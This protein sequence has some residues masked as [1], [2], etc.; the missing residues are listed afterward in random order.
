MKRFI[1]L[2]LLILGLGLAIACSEDEP[3]IP[4]P[5]FANVQVPQACNPISYPN[6]GGIAA[7]TV[8]PSWMQVDSSEA[9]DKGFWNFKIAGTL[10]AYVW[11]DN[12]SFPGLQLY[13]V[14]T[15]ATFTKLAWYEG[16][17]QNA[18]GLLGG[19]EQPEGTQWPNRRFVQAFRRGTAHP[20]VVY[21][22]TSLRDTVEVVVVP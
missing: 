3:T 8:R 21:N 18:I 9:A 7:V 1:T 10:T 4:R 2:A 14:D 5:S 20:Y 11:R 16:D 22:G 13:C 19:Y 15:V 17:P 12:A 6:Y